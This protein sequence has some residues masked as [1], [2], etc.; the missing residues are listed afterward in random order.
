MPALF[1]FSTIYENPKYAIT[2]V[3]VGGTGKNITIEILSKN[4][5]ICFNEDYS[6]FERG[7]DQSEWLWFVA[8]F[9]N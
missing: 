1:L 8:L 5:E 7:E 6:A 9:Q 4:K 3:L 2:E